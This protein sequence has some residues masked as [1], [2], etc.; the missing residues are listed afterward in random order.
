MRFRVEA[1]G[2]LGQPVNVLQPSEQF[3]A[4]GL[5]RLDAAQ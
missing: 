3:S 2:C 5:A 4:I 1:G